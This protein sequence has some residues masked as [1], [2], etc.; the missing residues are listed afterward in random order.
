M[1]PVGHARAHSSQSVQRG[2]SITGKPKGGRMSNGCA[3]VRTPVFRLSKMI[4]NIRVPYRS[5]P[6]YERLKLL[7]I[8]GKS[9]VMLPG[10]A[11]VRPGQ[12]RKLGS[13]IFTRVN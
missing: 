8:T 10:T 7:L 5:F 12:F 4:L 6:E 11:C 3:S 13:V 9:G 2:N 1:A